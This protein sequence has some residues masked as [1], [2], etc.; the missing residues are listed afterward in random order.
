METYG[1]LRDE[2][3]LMEEMSDYRSKLLPPAID[4][5][6]ATPPR[7]S[8]RGRWVPRGLYFRY[9]RRGL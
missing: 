1:Y 2:I 9:G 3:M 6:D 4:Y 7:Y 8:S 5:W